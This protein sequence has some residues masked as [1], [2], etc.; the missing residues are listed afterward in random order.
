MFYA[1]LVLWW[2]LEMGGFT[3]FELTQTDLVIVYFYFLLFVFGRQKVPK[4]Q[5]WALQKEDTPNRG[6]DE[7]LECVTLSRK[8]SKWKHKNKLS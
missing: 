2:V 3:L 4:S 1:M 6:K 5:H 8:G 7:G